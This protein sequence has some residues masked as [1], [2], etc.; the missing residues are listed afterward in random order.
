MG[1]SLPRQDNNPGRGWE[2]QEEVLRQ[3]RE[4]VGGGVVCAVACVVLGGVC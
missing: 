3:L 1:S 4:T 2:L